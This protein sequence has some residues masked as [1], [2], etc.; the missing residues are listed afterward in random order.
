VSTTTDRA[1]VDAHLPSSGVSHDETSHDAEE[2]Q[3]DSLSHGEVSNVYETPRLSD[4]DERV[5][6]NIAQIERHKVETVFN[7]VEAIDQRG[8]GAGNTRPAV[9]SQTNERRSDNVSVLEESPRHHR[10]LCP[11]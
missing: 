11:V 1:A 3:R 9:D 10:F 7:K 8:V 6:V 5:E 2:S 4:I